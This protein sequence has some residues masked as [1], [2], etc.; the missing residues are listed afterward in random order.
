MN[1]LKQSHL[2]VDIDVLKTCEIRCKLVY[3]H[4][5]HTYGLLIGT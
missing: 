1:A 5:T 4:I 2:L 3:S